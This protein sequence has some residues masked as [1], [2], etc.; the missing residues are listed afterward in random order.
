MQ[1]L[2]ANPELTVR[3]ARAED[4]LQVSEIYNHY[5]QTSTITFEEEPVSAAEMAARILEIQSLSYP[6]LVATAA[7]DVL[8]YAYASKWKARAAYKHSSEIT[9]YVR[10][11]Q[12]RAGVGSALYQQLLPALKA[13]GVR[14]AI[15]GV[16]LPND[17][18]VRLHEKFGFEK[19][20]HFREV[21]FKFNRWIDVA[22]W[23]RIL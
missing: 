1:M 6:W 7:N 4:A 14:A 10:P 15:G 23:Q 17:A 16:A 2:R 3:S 13:S 12:E 21:G 9:V 18:S 11:G 5:I 22:Y 19:C 20:A 8:G